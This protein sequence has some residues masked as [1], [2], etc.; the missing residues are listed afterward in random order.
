MD[1]LCSKNHSKFLLQKITSCHKRPAVFFDRD[2]V[3]IKDCNYISD[4]NNVVLEK[5]VKEI[6]SFFKSKEWFIFIVTNQSGISRE[7]F[8]WNDYKR[9]TK[10]FLDLI[11]N[12]SLIHGIYANGFLIVKESNWRKPNPGMILEAS[13]DFNVDLENSIL[14]GDRL[15]DIKA[16]VRAGLKNIFHVL[17]GHG[18]NERKMIL[19]NYFPYLQNTNKSFYKVIFKEGDKSSNLFLINNLKDIKTIID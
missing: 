1:H 4:P 6:L 3:L 8:S 10:K 5:D 7:Y 18:I 15:S 9:V 17:T 13:N 12:T 11:G 2:G 19:E 16:G 14:I